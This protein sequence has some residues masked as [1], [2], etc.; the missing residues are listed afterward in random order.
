MSVSSFLPEPWLS[1]IMPVH[2][3]EQWIDAALGSIAAEDADGVEVLIF[4]SSPTSVSVDRARCYSDRLRLRIHESRDLL[5]WHAKTNV[6]VKIAQ[7]QHVCWLHQDDLWLPGR[8]AEV[9]SWIEARPDVPLHLAPSMII[10]K[11][12]HALGVWR[13][14]LSEADELSP[15]AVIE[16][17]LVQNFISAP[18]PVFRRDAWLACGG[19]DEN[20]WYTADWD[21]WLRLAAIGPVLY[22]DRITTAFRVHESSQTATRSRKVAEFASQLQIVFDRHLPHLSGAAASVERAGRASISVNTALAAASAG[23]YSRLWSAAVEVLRLGPA[24]VRCYLRDSRLWDRLAP[25]VR[26]KLAGAF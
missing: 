23:D 14:P 19:M 3:G 21:V 6:G 15:A 24:G 17:L 1:V 26:A 22:H 2:C 8:A 5:M 13:C 16:R 20:L 12:G 9:R 7:A 10:D 4:D 25:R 18:A 11:R